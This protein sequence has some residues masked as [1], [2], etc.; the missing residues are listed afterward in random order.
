LM[1]RENVYSIVSLLGLA[2]QD[3]ILLTLSRYW[4]LTG[5]NS[6]VSLSYFYL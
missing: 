2:M 1:G 5:E 4:K 6:S 3:Q